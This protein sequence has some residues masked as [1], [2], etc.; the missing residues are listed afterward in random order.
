MLNPRFLDALVNWPGDSPIDSLKKT[1]L[2]QGSETTYVPF[3]KYEECLAALYGTALDRVFTLSMVA[4]K[5]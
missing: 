4:S 2:Q 5:A 1:L 3:N